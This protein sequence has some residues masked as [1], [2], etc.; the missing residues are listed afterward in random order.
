MSS[1]SPVLAGGGRAA[2]AMV[3]SSGLGAGGLSLLAAVTGGY[4]GGTDT[5][6][7]HDQINL[8]ILCSIISSGTDISPNDTPNPADQGAV[9]FCRS[10]ARQ[11]ARV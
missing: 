10:A 1:A 8:L 6:V 11:V 2:L 9:I 5:T 7:R 4:A 3:T